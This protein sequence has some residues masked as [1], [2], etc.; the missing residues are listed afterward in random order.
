MA[1]AVVI[2]VI[3]AAWLAYLLPWLL[4]YR[5]Q[6]VEESVDA[7]D[8]F[9][10]SM[11]IL[12]RGDLPIPDGDG[13]HTPDR[14]IS[15]PL[16]RNAAREEIALQARRATRRRR[17]GLAISLLIVVAGTLAPF[18]TPAPV[19]VVGVGPAM[20][21]IWVFVAH[22]S[23]GII[24]RRLDRDL[25]VLAHGWDEKTT[26]IGAAAPDAAAGHE[27]SVD[28]SRPLAAGNLHAP[29]AVAPLTYAN[30]PLLPRSVRT[31]DLSA[32]LPRRTGPAFPVAAA[33]PQEPLPLGQA[34]SG[35]AEDS[36]ELRAVG[37]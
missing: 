36:G 22:A 5:G 2:G 31:V 16:L 25:E 9:A 13:E 14:E 26:V 18:A 11:V 8:S 1:P 20:L 12:R 33:F 21:V 3:C 6:T 29:V 15:T 7:V 24:N 37:E 27:Q 23:V 28:L 17:I 30:R 32:P 4:K 35:E 10:Q 34:T 19:W